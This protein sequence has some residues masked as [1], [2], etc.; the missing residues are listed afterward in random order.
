MDKKPSPF[1]QKNGLNDHERAI[2]PLLE[3]LVLIGEYLN[4]LP[5][6]LDEDGDEEPELDC[7][8]SLN[9][10]DIFK[11]IMDENFEFN[12]YKALKS[13]IRLYCFENKRLSK[14]IITCCI[15][16]L[17]LSDSYNEAIRELAVLKDSLSDYRRHCIFGFPSVMDVKVLYSKQKFGLQIDSSLNHAIFKYSS[18]INFFSSNNCYLR[19]IAK[20]IERFEAEGFVALAYLLDMM[21]ENDDVF[22]Y[23]IHL[24][25]PFPKYANYHDCFVDF[26]KHYFDKKESSLPIH[27]E[28]KSAVYFEYILVDRMT[29]LQT[30]YLL[31]LKEKHPEA[32]EDKYTLLVRRIQD[33]VPHTKIS[34]ADKPTRITSDRTNERKPLF[35]LNKALIVGCI[36]SEDVDAEITLYENDSDTIVLRVSQV[37]VL[38]TPSIPT[39]DFNLAL[40]NAFNNDT[41]RIFGSIP[42]Q[43]KL[44]RF[45]DIEA[46]TPKLETGS[47]EVPIF[48]QHTKIVSAPRNVMLPVTGGGD[49]RLSDSDGDNAPQRKSDKPIIISTGLNDYKIEVSKPESTSNHQLPVPAVLIETTQLSKSQETKPNTLEDYDMKYFRTK[50]ILK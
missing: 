9:S 24:P 5:K 27:F 16:N 42:A 35:S 12:D 21:L 34:F 48:H 30:K 22:E 25:S 38:A 7:F 20:S 14:D 19:F 8:R 36:K 2:E 28:K 3:T 1:E 17:N 33:I 10:S 39:G 49:G 43:S 15:R 26:I 46:D 45:L 40:P 37:S 47:S 31:W 29:K 23:V 32:T 18:P 4:T 41:Q 13:L 11:K 50:Y 6:T 44:Y